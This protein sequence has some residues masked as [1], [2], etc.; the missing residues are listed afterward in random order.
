MTDISI[1][2][3]HALVREGLPWVAQLDLVC[4]PA[5][6]NFPALARWDRELVRWARTVEHAERAWNDKIPSPC[7][8]TVHDWGHTRNVVR[9]LSV[10]CPGTLN[11]FWARPSLRRLEAS[12]ARPVLAVRL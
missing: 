5:P 3:F 12:G 7:R 6:A 1:D 10:E 2:D 4:S 9:L 11:E 8:G